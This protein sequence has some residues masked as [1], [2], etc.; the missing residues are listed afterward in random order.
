MFLQNAE[1]WNVNIKQC[2]YYFEGLT[3]NPLFDQLFIQQPLYFI[4]LDTN[5]S[6]IATNYIRRNFSHVNNTL[7]R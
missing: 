6:N 2:A 4:T 3:H 5:E 7:T 1:F